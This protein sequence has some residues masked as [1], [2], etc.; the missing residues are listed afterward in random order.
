MLI[1]EIF[2]KRPRHQSAVDFPVQAAWDARDP[3]I[4]TTDVI[5]PGFRN[6][7][8]A[9]AWQLRKLKLIWILYLEF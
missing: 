6:T 1:R 2:L 3:E 9:S 4:Y 7:T 5:A 8:R